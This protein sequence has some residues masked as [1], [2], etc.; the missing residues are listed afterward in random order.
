MKD[1][2]KKKINTKLNKVEALTCYWDK[3]LT[4]ITG[5]AINFKDELMIEMC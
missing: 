3:I 5:K 1:R 2:F 4:N